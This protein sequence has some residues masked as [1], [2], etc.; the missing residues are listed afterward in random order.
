MRKRLSTSLVAAPAVAAGLVTPAVAS[1]DE[2]G[3]G[4]SAECKA[5]VEAAKQEHL[6]NIEEGKGGV[7][8]SNPNKFLEGLLNGYGTAGMPK[9][10]DCV[11]KE[12]QQQQLDS[13]TKLGSSEETAEKFLKVSQWTAVIAGAVAAVLQTYAAIAKFNPAVLE[14]LKAALDRLGIKY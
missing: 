7:N 11:T 14:P 9:Q 3:K 10:P 12:A 8:L 13:L 1:A 2:T 4:L 5:Q 6:K